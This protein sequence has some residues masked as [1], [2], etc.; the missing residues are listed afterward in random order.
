MKGPG[1]LIKAE[2]NWHTDIGAA[3]VGERVV[4]RGKD[5]FTELNDISWF[6]HFI[7]G[8]TN[9]MF[10]D[11]EIKLMEKIWSL[12]MSYP[13]PRIWNNRIAAL[14]ASAKSTGALAIAASTACSEA[15]VYGT[16]AG[17]L[18]IDF[19]KRAQSIVDKN[20]D[21]AKFVLNELKTNRSIPGFGRPV[22]NSDERITPLLNEAKKLGLAN[23]PHTQLTFEIEKILYESRYKLRMNAAGINSALIADI[24]FTTREQY[25]GII[26]A[27]SSGILPC[28][29]DAV[30][31]EE[32]TFFPLPCSRLS[33]KGRG[34][35]NW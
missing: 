9:K 25:Y 18:A 28:F 5:L 23:G 2:D 7:F 34:D 24:G 13:D 14:S 30:S 11:N 22:A 10:S 15:N 3:F 29:I 6:K 31:H 33:Y 32:G 16:N 35:R 1:T 8:I 20:K 26:I 27:F 17:F 21:L 12:T 4:F 19:I